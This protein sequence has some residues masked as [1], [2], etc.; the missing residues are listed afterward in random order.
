M[1][2]YIEQHYIFLFIYILLF[3][4]FIVSVKEGNKEICSF[5]Y[6]ADKIITQMDATI[7]KILPMREELF[8]VYGIVNK[9]M[10]KKVLAYGPGGTIIKLENGYLV[11]PT[12]KADIKYDIGKLS[13]LK[14]IC[15]LARSDFLYVN[16]P[17]KLDD[18]VV[19]YAKGYTGNGVQNGVELLKGLTDRGI[20]NL[21]VRESVVDRYPDVYSAF[22]KT[23]HHWTTKAGLLGAQQIATYLN[24]E[25]GYQL[26]IEA[27]D[28]KQFDYTY[29][30]NVWLGESG[31]KVSKS[32]CGLDD[33]TL[34]KP[35]YDTDI[36]LFSLDGNIIAEGDFSVLVDEGVYM[37]TQSYYDA[38]SWHYSYLPYGSDK[39][40]IHNNNKSGKKILLIKD[41]F[42]VVVA[43]FLAMVCEDLAMWDMRSQPNGL[44]EYISNSD[45]DVVIVAYTE[46]FIN[47]RHMFAFD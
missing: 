44:Y 6:S 13:E 46:G 4:F 21:N 17:M 43:P 3:C 11:S 18:D 27:I 38:D 8:E 47:G 25:L 36:T 16:Y 5:T 45:F 28:D 2:K 41:S 24:E 31:R 33:F 19:I 42:S 15:Q 1:K 26:N 34:I 40:V 30:Y 37:D 35:K 7:T 12:E 23:D 10:N 29:Y 22:Y 39:L 32:Y 20:Y 14:T 9:I